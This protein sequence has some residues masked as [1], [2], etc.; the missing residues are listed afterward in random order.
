MLHLFLL[1][2]VAALSHLGCYQENI[3]SRVFATSAGV[4][5]PS[6]LSPTTCS[7]ACARWQFFYA[8]LTEGRFC[9][10]S[11]QMPTVVA[12]GSCVQPCTDASSGATCGAKGFVDVYS[13][14]MGITGLQLSI[15]G[16]NGVLQVRFF[17]IF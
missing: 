2:L 15:I 4:Y 3:R 10:C 17:H 16:F 7:A 12:T 6:M 13:S 5:D 9:L 8:G 11:N 1:L 14:S